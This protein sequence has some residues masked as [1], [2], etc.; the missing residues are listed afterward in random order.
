[1]KALSRYSITALLFCFSLLA[2]QVE[3]AKAQYSYP[4][5]FVTSYLRDC[6][7]SAIRGNLSAEQAAQLCRCMLNKF[8]NQYS[9][10]ELQTM[11]KEASVG[12]DAL[13]SLIDV[14]EA[15]AVEQNS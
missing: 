5:N 12:G 6:Q 1:M 8:Q 14:G 7:Q 10:E 2:S 13:A 15:C 11:M 9:H 4:E 3:A